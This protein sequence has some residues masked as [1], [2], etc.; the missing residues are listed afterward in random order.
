MINCLTHINALSGSE[1]RWMDFF[2]LT[3]SN[4]YISL[5][6]WINWFLYLKKKKS[7]MWDFLTLNILNVGFEASVVA[8]SREKS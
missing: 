1:Y 5:L 3:R 7:L 8:S 4:D 2:F 6:D